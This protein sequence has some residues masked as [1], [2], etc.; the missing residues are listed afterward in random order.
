MGLGEETGI[1]VLVPPLV[2]QCHLF[3]E[4]RDCGFPLLGEGH[5]DVVLV[6]LLWVCL[7]G[8]QMS[9]SV[10]AILL[11]WDPVKGLVK[12]TAQPGHFHS[13]FDICQTHG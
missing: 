6:N 13:R 8:L 12:L 3:G 7:L 5:L 1:P 9:L 2:L 10:S 4:E 11:F